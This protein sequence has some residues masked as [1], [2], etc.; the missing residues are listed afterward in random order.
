[1]TPKISVKIPTYNCAEYLIH[2]INSILNQIEFDLDLLEIEVIDDCSTLDNPEEIIKKYGQGRVNFFRQSRNVGAIVNFN[3]CID[4]SKGDWIHILHGDDLVSNLFYSKYL[5]CIESYS[6]INFISSRVNYVDINNEIIWE[7]PEFNLPIKSPFTTDKLIFGNTFATPSVMVKKTTYTELG[8]FKQKLNHTADWE[9][10]SRIL[11]NKNGLLLDEILSS[12]RDFKDSDTKKVRKNGDEIKDHYNAVNEIS[13]VYNKI[14]KS[15]ALP[16]DIG[17][18]NCLYF[19]KTYDIYS[20]YKN[21]K[22]L[23]SIST[24][25]EIIQNTVK[26]CFY[27]AKS[28]I[29]TIKKY[30]FRN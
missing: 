2:T 30:I 10:W 25:K 16:K 26:F 28:L 3:T 8:G 29:R 13:K 22:V 4:R 15:Y 1:M 14:E 7:Q 11:F 18:K 9:M 21:Y 17:I 27:F 12:W 20:F 6:D 19:I 24:R 5:N 23:V